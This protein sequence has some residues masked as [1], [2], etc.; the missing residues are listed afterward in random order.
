MKLVVNSF[1]QA[2]ESILDVQN[3][4]HHIEHV[5]KIKQG[6]N[7]KLQTTLVAHCCPQQPQRVGS[8]GKGLGLGDILSGLRFKFKSSWVQTITWGQGWVYE[9]IEMALP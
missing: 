9:I 4:C 1:L 2:S 7:K 6:N 5:K 3:I 8:S